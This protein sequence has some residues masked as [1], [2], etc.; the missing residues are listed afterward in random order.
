M[1]SGIKSALDVLLV[2][3]P[4]LTRTA[5]HNIAVLELTERCDELAA[6][7]DSTLTAHKALAALQ[8]QLGCDMRVSTRTRYT[9]SLW[10]DE[11][12]A[13]LDSL[14]HNKRHEA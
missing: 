1:T 3:R 10:A 7:L 2:D 9:C 8:A 4:L 12:A 13:Q 11:L 6:E 5:F 14:R